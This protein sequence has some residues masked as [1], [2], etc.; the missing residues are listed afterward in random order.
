GEGYRVN[1]DALH[2]AAFAG[3]KHA[4]HATD[5]GAGVGAVALALLFAKSVERVR[6]IEID[7]RAADLAQKNL[8]ENGW[9]SRGE[10]VCADVM[11]A[12]RE[13]RASTDL[14]VCNPPYVEPGRG[15]TPAEPSRARARFGVLAHF[16]EAARLVLARRGR[17]C[18]VYPGGELA[19]LL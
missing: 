4:R 9:A 5:L 10:I 12:A 8:D 13:H 2:L 17:A 19:T 3:T 6:L 11:C 7:R 16:A 18:F 15:R 14:V 1:V